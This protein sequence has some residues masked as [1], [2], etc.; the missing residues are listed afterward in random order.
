MARFRLTL[1]LNSGGYRP[2]Q[3][4]AARKHPFARLDLGYRARNG[5]GHKRA[6]LQLDS[7]NQAFK[8]RLSSGLLVTVGRRD[9]HAR[10]GGI[11]CPLSPP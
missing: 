4:S 5:N 9:P 6:W 7:I 10:W 1:V 3:S 11:V 8:P 2:R